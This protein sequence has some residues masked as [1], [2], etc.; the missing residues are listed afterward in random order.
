MWHRPYRLPPFLL[1]LAPLGRDVKVLEGTVA[2]RRATT[3]AA[4]EV[5][6][7][8]KDL[9]SRVWVAVLAVP[10]LTR[11]LMKRVPRRS[12]RVVC[13]GMIQRLGLRCRQGTCSFS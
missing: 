5:A 6:D 13:R 3:G 9:I 11:S 1:P 4:V 2:A 12:G 8:S 7:P 10:A